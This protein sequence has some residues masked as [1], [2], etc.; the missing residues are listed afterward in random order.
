MTKSKFKPPYWYHDNI[1]FSDEDI[2]KLKNSLLEEQYNNKNII[3][4]KTSY[5]HDPSFRPDR[6]LNK[7]YKNIID[8]ITKKVGIYH[9]SK[10]DYFFWSQLYQINGYHGPHNHTGEK[11]VDFNAD[12]SWVHFLD[13]PEQKCFRFTDTKG[14]ILVPDEQSSGDIICFPSWVWHEVVPLET[15]YLRLVTAGNI[16]FTSHDVLYSYDGP[17]LNSAG[18]KKHYT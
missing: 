18:I 9:L 4:H 12:I 8:D 13:V 7:Y 2:N 1:K 6:F 3:E 15:D 10:Y 14:N 16:G 11:G 17:P 5:N